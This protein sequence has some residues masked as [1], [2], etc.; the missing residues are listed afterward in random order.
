M[1]KSGVLINYVSKPNELYN[2]KTSEMRLI[3]LVSGYNINKN[4]PSRVTQFIGLGTYLVVILGKFLTPQLKADM[5]D[6]LGIA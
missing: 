4:D 6:T 2:L 1:L 5:V 3:R